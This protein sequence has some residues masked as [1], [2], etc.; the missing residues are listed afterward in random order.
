MNDY[1]ESFYQHHAR[2]YAEV[3]SQF[4]QSVYLKLPHTWL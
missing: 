3:S 4:L 2:R 1:S